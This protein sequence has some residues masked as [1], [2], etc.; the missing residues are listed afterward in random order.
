LLREVKKIIFNRRGTQINA[1]NY[2]ISAFICVY[3]PVSAVKTIRLL[4]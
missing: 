1:D 2:L 3:L 4:R